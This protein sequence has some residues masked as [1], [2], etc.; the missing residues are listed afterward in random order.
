MEEKT[1]T[2]QVALKEDLY[3]AFKL[4]CLKNRQSVKDAV[5]ELIEYYNENPKMTKK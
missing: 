4:M 5:T 3:T 2:V 1:Y